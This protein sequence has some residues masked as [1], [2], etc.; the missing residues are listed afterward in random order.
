MAT[1]DV[2]AQIRQILGR[3]A[4]PA[5]LDFFNKF[6]A[7]EGMTSFELGQMLQSLP[8]FQ[9][10]QLNKDTQAYGAQLAQGDQGILDKAAA[11]AQSRFASLG[12]PVTSGQVGAF[13]Q[14][15]QNLAQ[16]RQNSLAAFYG[17]GLQS[18]RALSQSQGQG[19]L[20]RGY[21]LRD[22]TRQRGYQVEDRNYMKSMYDEY[23]ARQARGQR[24]GA[25]GALGGSL[26]GAG[27]GAA[28]AAPTGGM[29]M[30]MGAMLGSQMG[31]GAGRNAGG[32]FGGY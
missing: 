27:L 24:A 9:G 31:G 6:M 13:A 7:Q 11:T 26:L 3:D 4:N 16:A 17:Q 30:G 8:E 29:S 25:M 20:E 14:T 21:G 15:A 28:F 23:A 18:N 22:E 5:E 1:S 32:L 10:Q 2:N 12:R 19:A